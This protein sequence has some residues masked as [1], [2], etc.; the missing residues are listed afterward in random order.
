MYDMILFHGHGEGDNGAV[1]N[2]TTELFLARELTQKCVDLL[3]KKGVSVLTNLK[4]GYN[5]YNRNIIN[6]QVINYHMG[7]T[8]HLNASST[9]TANGTEIIVPLKEKY[10]K[11]E[12]E[13]L[14]NF[15]QLGFTIRGLKSRDYNTE[16]FSQRSN[17]TPLNGTDYYKE[18]R[19]A[20][21]E[22]NS[23][24]IIET[25]FI[26]NAD[27]VHR[28]RTKIN[29]IAL[30]I[31][32][33]YLKEMG[34]EPYNKIIEEVTTPPDGTIYRVQVGAFGIKENAEKLCNE[35]K[36]KGYNAIVKVGTK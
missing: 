10:L 25:C 33:P 17:G 22:C 3:E 7:A 12:E 36:V 29:E 15:R 21:S 34:K 28:F 26:S 6:G 35:L 31:V 20:F 18:I 24:S 9:A 4:T 32:N 16:L 8:I 23:L 19:Q 2:G 11:L 14:Y 13:I 30:A 5:N 1:G 27:D